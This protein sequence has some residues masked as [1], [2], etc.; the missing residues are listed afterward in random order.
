V[1]AVIQNLGSLG[2]KVAFDYLLYA[3]L[4]DYSDSIKKA[5]QESLN[6]LNRL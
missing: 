5:A 6:Q 1:L 3:R 4:L 2:D